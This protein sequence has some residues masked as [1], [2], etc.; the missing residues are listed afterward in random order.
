MP[1][2]DASTKM[3]TMTTDVELISGPVR[4]IVAPAD[5]GRLRQVTV[6][7]TELLVA[8]DDPFTSGSYPMVP[9][10][11]RVRR[12]RFEFDGRR[13]SVPANLPPHAIH[14]VGYVSSWRVVE[15]AVDRVDI[16]LDIDGGAS[17]PFTC[18]ARQ[19]ISVQP[20]LLRCEL[21][22]EAVGAPMPASIGWHP[23]FRKPSAIDFRPEAMYRRDTDGIT[24]DELVGV[25]AGPW[26][27]CFVNHRPVT[28]VIDDVEVTLL[29]PCTDWVVYDEPD[30]A[31][32]IEPQSAPPDALNI[33]QRRLD[34]GERL[35]ATY[36]WEFAILSD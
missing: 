29:S 31:T 27:D 32:C 28:L 33:R 34:P 1:F 25:P 2:D 21:S 10:A 3:V 16:E 9:F 8:G 24:V 18:R 23:W 7:S 35:A 30:H 36:E 4:A 12:G 22:V 14:G 17:W 6:G 13:Y 11:G 19:W 5:G 26:D 20:D 15:R